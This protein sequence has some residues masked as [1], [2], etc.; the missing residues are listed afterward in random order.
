MLPPFNSRG[1]LP[2]GD[3]PIKLATLRE[4]FLVRGRN[5]S[6]GAACAENWDEDWRATLVDN[7]G[8]LAQPLWKIGIE[9]IWIDGSFVENNATPGDIDGYFECHPSKIWLGELENELIEASDFEDA[10]SIWTWNP[11]TKTATGNGRDLKFLFWHRFRV[12]LYPHYKGMS[13]GLGNRYGRPL[14]FP[15]A[16]RL[17]R[18]LAPK[19]IVQL[20]PDEN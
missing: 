14:E 10:A 11:V 19:G 13:S 4:S 17:S 18:G 6:N 16:F 3:Y 2:E 1:L 7:L 8:I 9:S 12:E 20:L 5:A 15:E